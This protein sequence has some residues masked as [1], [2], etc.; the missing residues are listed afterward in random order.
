MQHRFFAPLNREISQLVLGSMVMSLDQLDL[1]YQLLDAWMEMGGNVVDTA[2][3]YNGGNSERALGRWVKDRGCRAEIVILDKGA[4]HT[5]DRRRVTPED[6]TCDMRDNLARLKTDY[7]DLFVLHRDDPN[8]PV[9]EIVDV[10]NMHR[11]AGRIR[12]FGGSNWTPDRLDAANAYAA[13]TGQQGFAVSSPNLSLAA[14][15][16]AVW[17]GCVDACDAA[18]RAWYTRTQMPLF[19][20]SSQARGFFSGRFK[21]EGLTDEF[22]KRVYDSPE[23]WARLR[24]AEEYGAKHGYTAT[25]VALAWVLHQPFPVYPLIGPANL[26][27]LKSSV[28]ASEI[29]LTPEEARWLENG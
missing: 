2:H 9:D 25:Q 27:E 11:E 28:A 16:E 5:Q 23:N 29:R 21:Q 19:A 4:H 20:W 24:R 26:E 17:D 15:K 14:P 22:V 13:R 7:I 18:S 6:I 1:T 8:V 3:I 10:L 12:A